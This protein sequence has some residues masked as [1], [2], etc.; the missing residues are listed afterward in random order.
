MDRNTHS[1]GGILRRALV[2]LRKESV[3]RNFG[4]AIVVTSCVV[5]LRK[6]SV[7]RNEG[8][9]RTLAPCRQVALRKESVDRNYSTPRL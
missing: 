7:D 9:S 5:A 2:A 4:V 3:D 6:E 1:Q 8:K